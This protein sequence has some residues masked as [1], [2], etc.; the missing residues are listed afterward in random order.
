MMAP[1]AA[2]A[3]FETR[4]HSESLLTAETTTDSALPKMKDEDVLKPEA[5]DRAILRNARI[6]SPSSIDHRGVDRS[7]FELNRCWHRRSSISTCMHRGKAA[8]AAAAE[9]DR[10]AFPCCRGLESEADRIDGWAKAMGGHAR[11]STL[12]PRPPDGAMSSWRGRRT[13]GT[14]QGDRATRDL[15]P[16]DESAEQSWSPGVK[17]VH[18]VQVPGGDFC[19]FIRWTFP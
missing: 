4:D 1:A 12:A 5:E 2:A 19:H 18:Y 16:I 14:A 7:P 10:F 17:G 9:P 13:S 11:S 6:P 15:V 3:S 8:A